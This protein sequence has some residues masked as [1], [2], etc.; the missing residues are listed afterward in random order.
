VTDNISPS[1]S[2][3]DAG[4]RKSMPASARA[5]VARL[6]QNEPLRRSLQTVVAVALAYLAAAALSLPEP[7]WAVFSA[8]FVVQD[9]VGG[10]L[11]SALNRVIGAAVGLVL[12][13]LAIIV[14]GVEE[15]RALV[16]LIASVGVMAAI[17]GRWPR[18]QYGLV[19]VAILVVAPGHELLED[20]LLTAGAIAVGAVCGAAAGA[21][22]LPVTAHRSA[23]T[24][25][26]RAI[27]T[28]GRLLR[29]S[30]ATLAEGRPADLGPVHAEIERELDQARAMISQSRYRPRSPSRVPSQLELLRHVD[31]LWYS[32]ALA[33]RLS[34]R[35]LP[36]AA[37]E[38]LEPAEAAT[39]A[40]CRDLDRMGEAVARG[41]PPAD[42]P[43]SRAEI[44]RLAGA[45]DRL[46]SRNAVLDMPQAAAED[47]FTLSFAW[48]QLSRNVED[49]AQCLREP[50]E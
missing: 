34:G 43:A 36:E 48:K 31:R 35:Q 29:E 16:S 40:L 6:R 47:L 20:T 39:R 33:D 19:T 3:G 2:P 45:I 8:L 30:F 23:R 42:R 22:V 26:G 12:G 25:L 49:L 32:L 13:V 21:A 27:R 50:G 28:C 5:A 10:T 18:L 46:R 44:E 38:I 4:P 15:W 7:S 14:V 17:S 41:E 1:E 11:T 9:S 24:H 37:A